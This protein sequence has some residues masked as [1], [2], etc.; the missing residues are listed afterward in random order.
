MLP[1]HPSPSFRKLDFVTDADGFVSMIIYNSHPGDSVLIAPKYFPDPAGTWSSHATEQHYSRFEYYWNLIKPEK[2]NATKLYDVDKNPLHEYITDVFTRFNKYLVDDPCHGVPMYRLPRA[3]I[4]RYH[5]AKE[6]YREYAGAIP[7]PARKFA[8][9][10]RKVNNAFDENKLGI[11]GSYLYDLYQDFSDLNLVFYDSAVEHFYDFLAMEGGLLTRQDIEVKV[12]P[13]G[14]QGWQAG[15]GDARSFL[16]RAMKM[17]NGKTVIAVKSR[18]VG[19]IHDASDERTRLGFWISN[20]ADPHDYGRFKK[21]SLGI[22]VITGHV[23]SWVDDMPS[24]HFQLGNIE[25]LGIYPA[26]SIEPSGT[27]SVADK[28]D[29]EGLLD[30]VKISAVQ[31]VGEFNRMFIFDEDVVAFGL[32]EEIAVTGKKDPVYELLVGGREIGGWIFPVEPLI[33]R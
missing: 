20:T 24:G 7:G 29:R 2:G 10:L 22:A 25:I 12:P 8:P 32:V 33:S 14:W 19:S 15:C 6:K 9:L 11:T 16:P 13:P 4:A 31:V 3:S 21:K 5:D 17:I 28:K 1:N 18:F 23:T 27:N 26:I 30:K